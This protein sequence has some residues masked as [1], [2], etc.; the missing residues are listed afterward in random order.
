MVNAMRQSLF[1]GVMFAAIG[2]ASH[3]NTPSVANL[4][5]SADRGH[6]VGP[7]ANQAKLYVAKTSGWHKPAL[8]SGPATEIVAGGTEYGA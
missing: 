5:K 1:I 6:T 3:A 4:A 8:Q 7:R 2:L